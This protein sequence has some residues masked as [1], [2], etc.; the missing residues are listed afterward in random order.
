MNKIILAAMTFMVIAALPCSANIVPQG[1]FPYQPPEAA[2]FLK[3]TSSSITAAWGTGTNDASTRYECENTTNSTFLP[4][5]PAAISWESTGL[6]YDTPYSFRARAWDDSATPPSVTS[7]TDLGSVFTTGKIT[8]QGNVLSDGDLISGFPDIRFRFRSTVAIN[9]SSCT[10]LVDDIPVTDGSSPNGRYDDLSVSSGIVLVSYTP[11]TRLS[12]S[13]K[14]ISVEIKNSNNTLY[15]E[16]VSGLRIQNSS[17][18]EFKMT[19]AA[20]CYP[21]PF[22]PNKGV[23]KIAYNLSADGNITIYMLD[24]T[25]RTILRRAI[26]SGQNGARYGYN[27]VLWDGKNAYGQTVTNDVYLICI[28]DGSGN[29]L[30]KT[31]AMVLK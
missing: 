11:K 10:V 16:S 19:S 22:D 17:D 5:S 20:L 31:R 24:A 28:A 26:L 25:G 1:V 8:S 6:I 30:G 9:S 4:P 2:P 29:I 15:I 7:W 12:G 18:T 23:M 21:N 3:I 14:K 27:E 13:P